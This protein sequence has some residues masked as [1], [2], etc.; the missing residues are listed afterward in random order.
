MSHSKV[1]RDGTALAL[2]QATRKKP[3]LKG[4]PVHFTHEV[5]GLIDLPTW[6]PQCYCFRAK[7]KT[8][9]LLS[10]EAGNASR[11]ACCARLFC[12][13]TD[14]EDRRVCR[15]KLRGGKRCFECRLVVLP[16]HHVVLAREKVLPSPGTL[17]LLRLPSN[18]YAVSLQQM[19]CLGI[20]SAVPFW[21]GSLLFSLCACDPLMMTWVV[22]SFPAPFWLASLIAPCLFQ[23]PCCFWY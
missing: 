1:P 2:L 17:F 12:W 4:K 7:W 23:F 15:G 14:G 21:R 22:L 8:I 3:L 20:L 16:G 5:V 10:L 19:F 13:G 9:F 11:R 18:I 6:C